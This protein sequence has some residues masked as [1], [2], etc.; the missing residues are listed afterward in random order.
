LASAV[1]ALPLSAAQ[2]MQG[3]GR[4]MPEAVVG[5]GHPFAD[6]GVRRVALDARRGVPVAA[7]DPRVVLLGHDVTVHADA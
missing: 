5:L 1:L 3:E 6:S 2:I 7:L 4:G